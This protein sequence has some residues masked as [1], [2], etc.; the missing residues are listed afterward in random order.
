M[1][2]YEL[3]KEYQLINKVLILFI[4]FPNDGNHPVHHQIRYLKKKPEKSMHQNSPGRY[5]AFELLQCF[6][7]KVH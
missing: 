2:Y 5:L 4:F 7:T 6:K 1:Q 3:R